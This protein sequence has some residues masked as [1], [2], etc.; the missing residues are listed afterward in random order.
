MNSNN[1][2]VLLIISQPG[3]MIGNRTEAAVRLRSPCARAGDRSDN[4]NPRQ[5]GPFGTAGC[6]VGEDAVK[7][8]APCG[9]PR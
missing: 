8:G 9:R 2:R 1:L 7:S 4:C 5:D 6:C 3:N